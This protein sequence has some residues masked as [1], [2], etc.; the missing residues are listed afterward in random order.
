MAVEF[1][2]LGPL[3]VLDGDGR[4]LPLGGAK[5]RALLAVLL[6]HPGQA[7]L[8]PS[9]RLTR[10]DEPRANRSGLIRTVLD[11]EVPLGRGLLVGGY[12][13]RRLRTRA[14]G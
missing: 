9:A 4:P 6:L 13:R 8:Y 2:I 5:Q 12:W 14:R 1:R 10:R 11:E 7:P 3:E